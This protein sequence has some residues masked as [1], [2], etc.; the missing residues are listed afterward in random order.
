MAASSPTGPPTVQ[1]VI[2]AA[3][4]DDAIAAQDL[5]R[6]LGEPD[7]AP[8]GAA[9]LTEISPHFPQRDSPALLPVF[10]HRRPCDA[11]FSSQRLQLKAHSVT[12]VSLVR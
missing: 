8:A 10:R 4:S 6:L 11:S 3:L 7:A 12:T 2:S 5:L 9:F 1:P